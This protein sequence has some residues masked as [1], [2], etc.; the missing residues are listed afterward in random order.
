M[1]V[2]VN[3]SCPVACP[4][5]SA[6]NVKRQSEKKDIRPLSDAKKEIKSM[7]SVYF[8]YHCVCVPSVLNVPN[9]AHAQLVGGR[10]QNISQKWPL[11]PGRK[12]KGSVNLKGRLPSSIQNQTSSSK[13]SV[14]GGYANPVRNLYLKEAL[15]ALIHKKTVERVR[16]R[17]S[18]LFQQAI[19]SSKTKSEMAPKLGSQ[20]SEQIFENI[21]KN[22]Q[23]GDPETT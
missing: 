15:H 18:S 22:I 8:V 14:D 12:F 17:T 13:R 3:I 19:H 21:F 16:V 11:G 2:Q 10:L 4:V 9:V 6:I 23:N 1:N 7:K 5:P 20:R